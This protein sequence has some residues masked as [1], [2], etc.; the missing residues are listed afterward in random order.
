LRCWVE[1]SAAALR[2]NIHALREHVSPTQIMAVVKA[3][4]YGHGLP[5]VVQT[6]ASD[7]EMFGVAN[8][9]E[10]QAVRTAIGDLGARSSAAS[11]LPILLL[12]AVL[13]AERETVVRERFIPSVSSASEAAAYAAHGQIRVHLVIDTG[14]GR[15]G[16][17]EANALEEARAICRVK[18]VQLT[19]VWSHL[20]VADEDDK[21]TADQLGR[22]HR[23]ADVIRREVSP[24]PLIH[25][26]NS[27]GAIKFPASAGNLIRTGLALY[28][29]SPRPDFQR[30]LLP[31]LTWKT[32]VI[33]IRDFPAGHG[34]SYGRTY[35]TPRPMRIATLAVGY[36]DGYQRQMSGR[37]AYVLINGQRCAMLGRITMDQI[38]VDVSGVEGV[39][40]GQEVVLL[41]RQNA[42]EI[43]AATVANWAGTIPWHVFTSLGPR[44]VRRMV[45]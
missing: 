12:G 20:P 24:A 35:I 32:R 17:W 21:Y 3:N 11:E 18:G 43:S 39:V 14:M 4:A 10:A 27:A 29:S 38:M 42:E 26:E 44:V 2:H 33:L 13:P 37:G 23:I 19:G 25:V 45:D 6:I 30:H 40:P 1:V 5:G 28:G 8:L 22:F 31:A 41:G 7:V 16:A 36:A 15:M 34:V 9:A